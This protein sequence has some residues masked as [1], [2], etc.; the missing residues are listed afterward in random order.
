MNE[1]EEK[2]YELQNEYESLQMQQEHVNKQ[3]E[4]LKKTNVYN[5]TFRIW[6]DGPFGTINGIYLSSF[7]F[8]CRDGKILERFVFLNLTL[9]FPLSSSFFSFL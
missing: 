9:L 8:F 3:L 4:K 6:H 1:F 2:V 5:D 7:L